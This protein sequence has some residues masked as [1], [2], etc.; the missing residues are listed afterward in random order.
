MISKLVPANIVAKV[1][2]GLDLGD[3]A[4]IGI[5]AG[6]MLYAAQNLEYFGD[7]GSIQIPWTDWIVGRNLKLLKIL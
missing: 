2:S 1:A 3:T 6:C 4:Q 7:V 5:A